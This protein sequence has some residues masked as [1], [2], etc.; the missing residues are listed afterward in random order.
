MASAM[1]AAH[2]PLQA[3]LYA[4]ALRRYLRWRRPGVAFDDQWAGVGYLFVRGM[5]GPATPFSDGMPS[6]VFGWRPSA[7]LVEH[8]DEILR[9]SGVRR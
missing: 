6:G 1:M 7:E 5:A 3:L 9:G 4:V 2:Y 8:A